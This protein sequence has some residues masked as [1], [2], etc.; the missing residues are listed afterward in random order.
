MCFF[1]SSILFLFPFKLVMSSRKLSV[2]MEGLF[3]KFGFASIWFL[4]SVSS[5]CEIVFVAFCGFSTLRFLF[6]FGDA[7]G[8]WLGIDR[9]RLG[10][11]LGVCSGRVDARLR[12]CSRRRSS[13]ILIFVLD[14]SLHFVLLVE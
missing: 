13:F 8:G 10:D 1:A 14:I 9:R 5:F 2:E 12:T 6:F 4:I 3:L 7:L 11:D